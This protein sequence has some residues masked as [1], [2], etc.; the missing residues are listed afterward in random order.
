MSSL[1][2]NA[3]TV[4]AANGQAP[5][6][7][8]L[9][10]NS[11]LA[12]Q[13]IKIGEGGGGVA[14]SAPSFTVTPVQCGS[15]ISIPTI[16]ATA[17]NPLTITLPNPVQNPGFNCKFVM[18]ADAT[19]AKLVAI[20]CGAGLCSAYLINQ[21]TPTNQAA[22]RYA[23]FT[24]T[25]LS[26]DTIEVSSNGVKYITRLYSQAAAGVSANNTANA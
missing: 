17:L 23:H 2:G 6:D 4:V 11:D 15:I 14:A 16:G 26:G 20:D 12:A 21:A 9:L 3:Y 8:P 7:G 13:A 5:I 18:S 24:G 25:A 1:Y 22:V 10:V 19:A